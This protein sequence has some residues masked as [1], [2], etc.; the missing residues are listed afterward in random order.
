M[1][2][3]YCMGDEQ[4]VIQTQNAVA[5]PQRN[6]LFTQLV[7]RYEAMAHGYTYA[8]LGDVQLAEDATQEAFLTAYQRLSELREP[9]AFAGWLRRILHTHCLRLLQHSQPATGLL[10]LSADLTGT[11]PSPEALL[12]RAEFQ[13]DVQNIIAS[14][15][16]EQQLPL[17]L[18]YFGDYSQRE[19][20]E[21]LNLS[22]AAVKKRLERARYR[23]EERMRDM[24]QEYLST[25][26][27]QNGAPHT[28]APLMEAAAQEGQYVLLETL[29]VEGMDINEPDQ[30]GQTLLHWAA[31]AG[32]LE[33]VELILSYQPDLSRRDRAGR[34]ALQAA[35]ECKQTEVAERLRQYMH[36]N[37]MHSK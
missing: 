9:K 5:E 8:I 29:L 17:L 1:S 19:I 4:L 7:H 12:E 28:F 32:H 10:E 34:T 16:Q 6:A 22:L 36:A 30:N 21:N 25:Q 11:E 14:L 3:E 15:P 37:P 23:L 31:R 18:Y 20:A 26:P 2:A 35:L 33:A 27:T 13:K 24:A